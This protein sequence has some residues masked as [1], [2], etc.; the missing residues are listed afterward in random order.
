[1]SNR[2]QAF[3]QL[4]HSSPL[5]ILPNA[6]N[7]KS[8]LYFQQA[9]YPAVATSSAAVANS[10]GYEDGET[11]PFE[12]YLLMVRRIVATV[13]IPVSVDIE[14]G[15]ANTNDAIYAN[16][17]ELVEL[18][19]AGINIEDSTIQPT[20]RVLKD[21][22][23]FAQT[24]AFL[25]NKLI[26]DQLGLFINARCD[27][28]LLNVANKQSESVKRVQLYETAGADGIFLPCISEVADIT[29]AVNSTTLP[30]NVMCIPGLPDFDTLQTLGVKRVSMGPFIF[31][32][33]YDNIAAITQRITAD[34]N[35][36]TL[37]K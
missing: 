1:M 33:V 18:G 23:D 27:T 11:M 24:I 3:K 28:Y 12:E 37:F 29:E 34:D 36:G 32:K 14:M 31:N 20:G 26:E 7:A 6:W 13:Q 16:I 17:R 2:F 10:L 4:H 9:Q 35:F 8:A 5:F 19:V 22:N 25:K 30:V 21:A 15:Y